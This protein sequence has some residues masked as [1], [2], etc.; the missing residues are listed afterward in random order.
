M[1]SLRNDASSYILGLASLFL[2]IPGDTKKPDKPNPNGVEN[3]GLI[4]AISAPELNIFPINSNSEDE[5]AR[6]LTSKELFK[7]IREMDHIY[8]GD[9]PQ[10]TKALKQSLNQE[11][12]KKAFDDIKLQVSSLSADE[13]ETIS[14][15]IVE[16]NDPKSILSRI[17]F[18]L[19][20][21]DLARLKQLA[22][23]FLKTDEG[24]Y[25]KQALEKISLRLDEPLDPAALAVKFLA[26]ILLGLGGFC[27]ANWKIKADTPVKRKSADSTTEIDK[28]RQRAAQKKK[29]DT[30]SEEEVRPRYVIEDVPVERLRR[31]KRP[32][33]S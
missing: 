10:L 15:F 17:Y 28:L 3:R 2:V 22:D 11:D 19:D 7:F 33:E 31:R 24:E 6:I 12:Q 20:A 23:D 18:D 8:A 32:K 25:F 9:L 30:K 16:N 1:F 26:F 13:L 4:E 29:R 5:L 14:S 27:L 21:K